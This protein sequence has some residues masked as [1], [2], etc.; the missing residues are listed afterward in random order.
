MKYSSW[1]EFKTGQIHGSLLDPI[2]DKVSH[3]KKKNELSGWFILNAA[4][5]SE[6]D[7]VHQLAAPDFWRFIVVI[8]PD[9][10]PWSIV[11]KLLNIPISAA[12]LVVTHLFSP[13][14]NSY[15]SPTFV[16]PSNLGLITCNGLK[17]PK[18]QSSIADYF[19]VAQLD[20][21]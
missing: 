8:S 13:D 15:C 17:L 11:W 20:H 2:L 5:I 12:K 7:C 14:T 16:I 3:L 6:E 4:A 1:W 9:A 19:N 10:L 18:L 21:N